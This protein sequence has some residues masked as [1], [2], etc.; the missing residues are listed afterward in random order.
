MFVKP[1]KTA[2]GRVLRVIHPVTR[3]QVPEEG[4]E[5]DPNDLHWAAIVRDGDLL[6]AKSSARAKTDPAA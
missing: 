2:D 3:I 1:G 5:I 6:E 4:M